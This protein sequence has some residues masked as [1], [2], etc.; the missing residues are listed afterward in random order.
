MVLQGPGYTPLEQMVA[1]PAVATAPGT[2][3]QPVGTVAYA[4]PA[5]Q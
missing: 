1:P 2:A 4:A 5:P 3:P